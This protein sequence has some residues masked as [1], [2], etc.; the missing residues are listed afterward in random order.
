[1]KVVATP[2][3]GKGPD[4]S[5]FDPKAGLAFS[6]NGADGTLTIVREVKPDQF[7]VEAT[8]PTQAGARTMALDPSTHF[9]YLVPAPAPPAELGAQAYRRNYEPGSFVILVVSP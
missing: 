7:E 4:A 9:I 1:G 6:S 8:V 5:A 3:I 2:A